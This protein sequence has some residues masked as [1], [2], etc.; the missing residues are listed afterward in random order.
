MSDLQKTTGGETGTIQGGLSDDTKQARRELYNAIAFELLPLIRAAELLADHQRVH[1]EL[2]SRASA[3]KSFD[4]ALTHVC[5]T[6][7]NPI[8]G[9]DEMADMLTAVAHRCM[10][11]PC[12]ER[13]QIMYI[14]ESLV[15]ETGAWE[16]VPNNER[17]SYGAALQDLAALQDNGWT[18]LRIVEID[19]DGDRWPRDSSFS[20]FWGSADGQAD[21]QMGEFASVAEARAALPSAI[22]E[23]VAQ[24]GDSGRWYIWAGDADGFELES[25]D[26]A[27]TAPG[28]RSPP[29]IDAWKSRGKL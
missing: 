7:R 11:D 5:G 29:T 6:W 22:A 23:H 4:A 14:I 1:S 2:D 9:G 15:A 24:G 26:V 21:L 17:A 12:C 8:T 16:P 3:D 27:H 13:G 10:A 19:D 20:L 18:G 25:C 28:L